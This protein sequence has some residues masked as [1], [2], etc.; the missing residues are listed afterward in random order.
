V[1]LG[2]IKTVFDTLPYP[3]VI[4][5]EKLMKKELQEEGNKI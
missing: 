3:Q 1:S 4:Q 5:V 2:E